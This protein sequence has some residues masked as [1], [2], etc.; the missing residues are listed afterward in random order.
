MGIAESCGA[1]FTSQSGR[2]YPFLTCFV[3]INERRLRT[4]YLI[5]M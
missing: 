4:G 3:Q 5:P 2:F 1:F